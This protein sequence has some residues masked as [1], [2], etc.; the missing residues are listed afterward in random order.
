MCKWWCI[1]VQF[2]LLQLD[3]SGEKCPECELQEIARLSVIKLLQLVI[4]KWRTQSIVQL[5][6]IAVFIRLRNVPIYLR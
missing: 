2:C 1:Y 3:R 4:T 5:I 6:L